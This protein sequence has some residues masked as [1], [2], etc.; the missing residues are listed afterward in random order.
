MRHYYILWAAVIALGIATLVFALR[1]VD[2][3]HAVQSS[4]LAACRA[5]NAHHDHTIA[6]LNHLAAKQ[7]K[8]KSVA[9]VKKIKHS[10]SLYY[11]LIQDEIPKLDCAAVVGN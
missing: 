4:R 6:F 7:E 9:G 8:G 10:L 11:I 1:T 3:S 5:Q 2:A